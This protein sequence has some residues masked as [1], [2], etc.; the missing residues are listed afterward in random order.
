MKNL[1]EKS[2]TLALGLSLSAGAVI[3]LAACSQQPVADAETPVDANSAAAPAPATAKM[4]DMST[5]T[6]EEK[7]ATARGVISAIDAEGGK[8][9]IE[10]EPIASLEWP[11]MTMGFAASPA[12]IDQAK[13]GDRV[14][15]D[16]VVTGS[17]GELKA[18]RPQ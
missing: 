9:T 1:F 16:L 8:I 4:D 14:E 2:R 13:V 12:L 17:A 6:A 15:F 3:G 11:A 7:S 5:A 10:H 18:I